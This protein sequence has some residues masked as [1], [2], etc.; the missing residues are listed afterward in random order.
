MPRRTP[1]IPSL[2][3]GLALLV[4]G[5][6]L[7][8]DAGGAIDLRFDWLGPLALGVVGA[9]LLAVGLSRTPD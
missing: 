6:V 3:A 8:L 7:A 5:A 9:I 1:D 2:V 4:F